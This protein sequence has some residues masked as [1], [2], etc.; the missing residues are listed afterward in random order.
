MKSKKN[1]IC[2]YCKRIISKQ[3]IT[4]NGCISC[5]VEYHQNK[6]KKKSS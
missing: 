2:K 3:F 5:D 4:K 1:I 6:N